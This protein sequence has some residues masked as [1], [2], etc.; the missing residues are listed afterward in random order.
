IKKYCID[1][2]IPHSTTLHT[3]WADSLD[4]LVPLLAHMGPVRD[5]ILEKLIADFHRSSDAVLCLPAMR[6]KLEDMGVDPA[7]IVDWAYGVD[8]SV[9]SPSRRDPTYYQDLKGPIAL[10]VAR[11]SPEKNIPRLMD[12]VKGGWPGSVVMIGDGPSLNE[13]RKK[14]PEITFL[15]RKSGDDLGTA[16]ASADLFL[17]PSLI[18]TFGLTTCEALASGLPVVALRHP[19]H[20]QILGDSEAGLIDEDLARGALA[21]FERIKTL[22]RAET[23]RLAS[24]RAGTFSI[25]MSV[26]TLMNAVPLLA[27]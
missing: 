24:Q 25:D 12:L 2:N 21:M 16:Y 5:R 7:K 26:R 6:T 4:K 22:G 19:A 15:G 3:N 1:N 17:Q 8:T 9:F 13:L 20:C 23:A 10:Y 14:Y 27:S 18:E 11:C